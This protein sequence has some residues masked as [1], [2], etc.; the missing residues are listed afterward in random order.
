MPPR[1]QKDTPPAPPTKVAGFDKETAIKYYLAAYNV[2]STLGWSYILVTLLAHLL[3]PTAQPTFAQPIAKASSTITRYLPFLKSSPILN[4]STPVQIKTIL[5]PFLI[6]YF[7]RACTAYGKVGERT[8]WVQ[9]LAVLEIVH[10]LLGFVKSAI[11]TTV[12]QVFSRLALVWYIAENFEVARNNPLYSSMVLAWSVTEIIRYSFYAISL[13][14][15]VPYPLLY[16]RYTTFYILYPIGAGSE[17]FLIYS[18]LLSGS[19]WTLGDYFRG[20]LFL[21]WW[22]SLYI[23]YTHMIKQRR[24][25]LGTGQGNVVGSKKAQ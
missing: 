10:V 1:K 24:K 9:T 4:K 25:V 21:V 14:T 23:L 16:L 6:P 5:P 18:T 13:F 20:T 3:I 7:L 2:V 22:P 15:Q 8:A 17:A 19:S 12:M 11:Q